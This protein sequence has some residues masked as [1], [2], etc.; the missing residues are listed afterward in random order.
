[1]QYATEHCL[2]H[3]VQVAEDVSGHVQQQELQRCKRLAASGKSSSAGQKLYVEMMLGGEDQ[4]STACL[5]PAQQAALNRCT[6]RLF[7]L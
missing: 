6:L 5:T 4:G 7:V 3:G 2:G 1:M